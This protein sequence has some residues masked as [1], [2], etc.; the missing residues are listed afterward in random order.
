MSPTA[1]VLAAAQER[2]SAGASER[3]GAPTVTG[4]RPISE[5]PRDGTEF[6]GWNGINSHIW[7]WNSDQYASK[8]RPCFTRAYARTLR[9]RARQPTHYQPL[10]APPPKET[11]VRSV[12]STGA[13]C[14]L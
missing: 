8:P 3:I 5:A 2:L 11:I 9:D 6:L 14:A 4:W 1:S 7:W 13:G 10:P 12:D